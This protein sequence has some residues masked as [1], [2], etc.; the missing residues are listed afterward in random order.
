MYLKSLKISNFR[1][2]GEEN[3]IIEFV[4]SKDNLNGDINI[5]SA[6]TLIVGK[7][8]SGKTT[9]TKALEKIIKIGKFESN[10]FNF[11]YLRTLLEEYKLGTFTNFPILSFEILVGIDS[12]SNLDLVTNYV[13]FMNIENIEQPNDKKDF[14][15][16]I[17][18][19]LKETTAFVDE[20]KI[21]VEKYNERELPFQKFLE[22][23]SSSE[24]DINYYDSNNEKITKTLFKLS[25]LINIEII[26]ADKVID[27]NSLSKT[28][29]EIIKYKAKS[30]NIDLE[31]KIEAI[32]T[33]MTE[34]ISSFN[35][36][37]VN[38]VLHEIEDSK[39]FKVKLSANL[40]FEK[41]MTNLI[42]YE[43]TE[44]NLDI[45]EGQFGLGYANLMTIIG[46]L[47]QYIEKYP[48]EE[49]HSKLNLICIEEPE[50]FMH[51][52]MQELFIK[53]INNA[54][55]VLLNGSNKKINSQL[56]ITTHSS[57]ILNSKIH[58][59]NSFNNINYIAI[60]NN[61]SYIINLN[62]EKIIEEVIIYPV[63]G[64]TLEA[65]L[66]R[67]EKNTESR[68]NNLKY[69]KKHI[70]FKVSEIF[71]SDAI[72]FVEG[73]TEETLLSYY[74]YN[75]DSLG[76]SK[77]Y[78]TIFNINGAHGLKYHNLIKQL[79]IPTL[80][81]TD[82]DIKRTDEEKAKA[83]DKDNPIFEQ[84]KS[85]SSR[86]TTNSTIIK[87]KGNKNLED[88]AD[89]FVD[90]NLYITFQKEKIN[91]CYATSL[92][93]SLILSNYD[94][95]IL[96]NSIKEVKPNIYKN[97]VG[98]DIIKKNLADNSYK[99]QKKLSD[100]K[101]N[102]ANTLLY[103]FSINDNIEDL[104]TLPKYIN[105]SIVWLKNKLNNSESE[106]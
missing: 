84:I 86:V 78:I 36:E 42:K 48:N 81:I 9:I 11:S 74:I 53:N 75:D 45:P 16:L 23:I 6:S 65:R 88:I 55:Q 46:Q 4:D 68:I 44:E 19:E 95:T 13:P 17:K 99:L 38:N 60:V 14:S 104:P 10:D 91:D 61:L 98:E 87:Y 39:R 27:E 1:K 90:E 20:V 89:Y 57:H 50:A 25:N 71:F 79:R 40:T 97:I 62:D 33:D 12:N 83:S 59:S 92:E 77:Y 66:I 72:I 51:P 28:F 8:N 106:G 105:D 96:N 7:N 21:L 76:L 37:S 34:E 31:E 15:V 73:I 2:F 52:Q 101:S 103:H 70:K 56:V 63:E 5:A 22:L 49:N 93:E 43:Y 94:N 29:T 80:I 58:T 32:N 47:I 26:S 82:I 41:L 100:D 35:T 67:E 64:E 69:L 54:V 18:Y 102:F 3:N 30:E 24:F 85:L